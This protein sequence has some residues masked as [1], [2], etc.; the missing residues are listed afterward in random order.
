MKPRISLVSFETATGD[1]LRRLGKMQPSTFFENSPTRAHWPSCHTS[2][3]DPP[4]TSLPSLSPLPLSHL[5]RLARV[6][7][8]IKE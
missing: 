1:P 7:V 4:V 3:A 8:G 6:V 5:G 2:R